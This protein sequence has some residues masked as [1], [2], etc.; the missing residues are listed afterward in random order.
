MF[1]AGSAGAAGDLAAVLMGLLWLAL[2]VCTPILLWR[3]SASHSVAVR[4]SVAPVLATSAA[5]AV[6][7]AAQL[8]WLVL[9][10]SAAAGALGAGYAVLCAAIPLMILLGIYSERLFMGQAL[11]EFVKQLARSPHAQPEPLMAATLRD[12]SLRFVT[13]I[14]APSG[15]GDAEGTLGLE[16]PDD[17]AVTWIERDHHRSA[18]VVYDGDLGDGDGYMQAAAEAALRSLERPRLEAD[19]LATTSDLAASR[20]RLMDSAAAERRRLERDLHDGVQQQLVGVRLR[21]EVAA[22]AVKEDPA[23]AELLLGAIGKQMDDVLGEV[24]S[25]ARGIYPPLLSQRGLID[26]LHAAART[27]PV[28]VAFHARGVGRYAQD[29]EVAVYFCCLE[30]LQNI[31]K[32]AGPEARARL[33][34]RQQGQRVDFEVRDHGVGFGPGASDA[35]SGLINMRDR[36]EAVGGTLEVSSRVGRGAVVRGSVPAT[37][38]LPSRPRRTPG[39][40]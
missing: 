20:V 36:I 27:S 32:H 8:L 26:A 6:L 15:R 5:A 18:A 24:R 37:G 19:L 35:G 39:L 23:R 17:Q 1:F 11:A 2:A 16:F 38:P 10:D 31:A 4:R 34:I 22:G 40:G 28:P 12:P 33:I 7:V 14:P 30:A 3:R 21:L 25:F 9:R 29:L 13:D